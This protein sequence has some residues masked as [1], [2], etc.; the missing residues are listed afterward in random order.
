MGVRR[1]WLSTRS[2]LR[3]PSVEAFRVAERGGRIV[4]VG[5]ASPQLD[6]SAYALSADERTLIGTFCYSQSDFAS[7]VAWLA[8]E[9]A[10]AEA[11]TDRFEALARGIH[12]FEELLAAT[13]LPNKVLLCP[14][15][16]TL[17]RR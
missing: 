14:D 15:P 5:M 2:A 3:A 11:V 17:L 12:V 6:F 1:A 7:T 9:P 10:V 13:E 16:S 8:A 4:M